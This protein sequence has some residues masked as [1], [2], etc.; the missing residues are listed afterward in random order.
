MGLGH[1]HV[2][3]LCPPKGAGL[4]LG[5]GSAHCSCVSPNPGAAGSPGAVG[6]VAE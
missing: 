1:T 3:G 5:M 2:C 4:A 6:V